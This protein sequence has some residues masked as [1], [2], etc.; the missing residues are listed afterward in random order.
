MKRLIVDGAYHIN[1]SDSYQKTKRFFYNFLENDNYRYKKYFDIFM[2]I[3][4]FMSVAVLIREVKFH[5]NDFW[6]YFNNFIV[7]IIFFI[8]YILRLWVNSSVTKILIKQSEYD[9]LL[10]RK[11]YLSKAL[12]EI[13]KVKFKY[14]LS[15]RAII[16][17]LAILPFFHQL[18]LNHGR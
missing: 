8:E 5:V 10:G 11:F 17:L 3:L 18:R 7:S 2:M 6:L 13:L 4:I 16:D 9:A 12:I 14:I 1:T 15:V